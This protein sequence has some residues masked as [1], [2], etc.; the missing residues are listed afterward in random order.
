MI[1]TLA[2]LSLAFL[3]LASSAHAATGR[4]VKP[5][6]IAAALRSHKVVDKTGP[7]HNTLGGKAGDAIRTGRLSN[8]RTAMIPG[9]A[10]AGALGGAL[11]HMGGSATYKIDMKTDKVTITGYSMVR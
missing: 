7:F 2:A 6:A 1:R 4:D 11:I 9:H 8:I 5:L 10:P 3:G